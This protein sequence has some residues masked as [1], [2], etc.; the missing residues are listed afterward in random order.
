MQNSVKC[1][2]YQL[3]RLVHLTQR[4]SK[5]CG[6]ILYSQSSQSECLSNRRMK[7]KEQQSSKQQERNEKKKKKLAALA[8]LIQL[9]DR[10]RL[11]EAEQKHRDTENEDEVDDGF[12]TVCSKRKTRNRLTI[13]ADSSGDAAATADAGE[14]DHDEPEIKRSRHNSAGGDNTLAD[15]PAT[16]TQEQYRSLSTDLRRRKRELESVPGVHLRDMGRRALLEIPQEERTPIFLTDI[17]HLLM[18]ALIGKKSPCAPDRWC[19]ADK[20]Q[21]LSHSVVLILDGLSLYHYMSNE[22]RFEATNRIF[23]TKLE[24]VLPPHEEGRIIDTIAQIPLTSVQAQKLINEHGSLES[25]VELNKDP[26]LLVKAIFPIEK[27]SPSTKAEAPNL[28]PDD[29]FPRTK[30]LLS[31]LQL[32]DEG[33]PIPLQ[34][35]LHARF[36][37]FKFTKKSY[38]PVTDRSPMYGVDCEMCRTITGENELTRISIVDEKY[39]TVYETL[40]RPTNKITDYLTQYSGITADIMQSVTKTLV[41]VQR[42]VSELLPPDAILVGQSLNSDLNAMRMMHPYVIDTSVCFN[43]SGVRKRKSKL[44]HLAQRFLQESIQQHEDGHDSIEDSLAT[45]KLVKKKLANSIEF[46][47]EILTQRKR[48]YDVIRAASGDGLQNNLLAHA[49]KRDKRTAIV[50]VGDLQPGLKEV[51]RKAEQAA[52]KDS[53]KTVY[54]HQVSSTKEA[55]RKVNEIALENALTIA[56]LLVPEQDFVLESAQR[57]AAKLDS[58][59]ERVWNA[60]AHNGLL[61]VLMGGSTE[62]QKGVAKFAIKRRNGIAKSPLITA[63]AAADS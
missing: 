13:I 30:L 26:T 33:Y 6:T 44:K 62:C 15:M 34:G 31:A 8:N 28:H 7:M 12:I 27:Q 40:V 29:K 32:V 23:D 48:I 11:H 52:S 54:V 3:L 58:F 17:Q 10:D 46:G 1:L 19:C 36:R 5:M 37:S 60:M 59:I 35:E 56:N 22:S 38:A 63:V 14:A 20:F 39:Q 45:L 42:E 57:T 53:C 50:T 61:M 21:S 16:L 4:V 49:A 51:I 24:V 41:D 9:N 43:I 25:A 18:S 2:L 55:V 47:D